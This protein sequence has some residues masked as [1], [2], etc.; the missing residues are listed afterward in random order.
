MN[1]ERKCAQVCVNEAAKLWPQI[2]PELTEHEK[3]DFIKRS[4]ELQRKIDIEK[5]K[6]ESVGDLNDFAFLKKAD[7][8]TTAST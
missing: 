2:E 6:T 1:N 8:P 4:E 5:N 3:A 7:T